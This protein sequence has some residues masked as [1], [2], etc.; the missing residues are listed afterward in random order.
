MCILTLQ[1]ELASRLWP[2]GFILYSGFRPD[3]TCS[4]VY[5]QTVLKKGDC[6]LSFKC[7]VCWEDFHFYAKA[8][9]YLHPGPRWRQRSGSALPFCYFSIRASLSLNLS[10][11]VTVSLSETT[12]RVWWRSDS[13]EEWMSCSVVKNHNVCSNWLI[14]HF[15]LTDN[16]NLF[17]SVTRLWT[18]KNLNLPNRSLHVSQRLCRSSKD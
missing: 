3:S 15:P 14:A 16:K 8:A 17:A 12:V 9:L 11:C 5:F 10:L 13:S 18:T 2:F 7:H 6:R 1:N 4:Q